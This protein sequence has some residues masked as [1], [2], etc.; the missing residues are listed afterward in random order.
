MIHLLHLKEL[1]RATI[2]QQKCVDLTVTKSVWTAVHDIKDNNFWKC[3]Y[4]L[5][6]AV[7]PTLRLF[8]YCN[9]NKTAMDKILFLLRRT[10]IARDK[11][12]EFL[13]DTKSLTVSK[14]TETQFK[15]AILFWGKGEMKVKMI[16]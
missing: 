3:L 4:V 5:F 6:S 7:F 15:R 1:L 14:V 13:N 12:V 2:H 9:T 8:C 16:M 11:S 10:T